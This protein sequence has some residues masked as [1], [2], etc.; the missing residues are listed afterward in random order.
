MLSSR[1]NGSWDN[2]LAP[3]SP[4]T[5]SL[6]IR[7]R[8]PDVETFIA[9][10]GANISPAGIFIHSSNPQPVD[11]RIRFDLALKDGTP[12]LKGEGRVI[13]TR[14]YDA[15]R[16]DHA[17]GMGVRFL[18][19]DPA[20]QQML[21]RIVEAQ[22]LAVD[23]AGRPLTTHAQTLQAFAQAQPG[24]PSADSLTQIA[25]LTQAT[26]ITA[27]APSESSHTLL[28]EAER[29][30]FALMAESGLDEPELL[31]TRQRYTEGLSVEQCER[32]LAELELEF[33]VPAA[34]RRTDPSQWKPE[35]TSRRDIAPTT[36]AAAQQAAQDKADAQAARD[37]A[38][39]QAAQDAADAQ[40]AQNAADA[41]A[42]QNAADAQAAQDAADAADAQAAQD[43]ADAQAAR[44]AADTA[45]AQAAQDA[46]DAQAAR[47]AA[48]AADAQA[49]QDAADAQAA[50]DAAD[51]A[52]AQAAQDAA[53]V[54]TAPSPPSPAPRSGSY[55]L[56][57]SILAAASSVA[58]ATRDEHED[59][60]FDFSE[61]SSSG[62]EP[63]SRPAVPPSGPDVVFRNSDRATVS[64]ISDPHHKLLDG[65][66]HRRS[67]DASVTLENSAIEIDDELLEELAVEEVEDLTSKPGVTVPYATGHEAPPLPHSEFQQT[68]RTG[69][70]APASWPH[71][72]RAAPWDPLTTDSPFSESTVNED[73]DL[74][75]EQA[76]VEDALLDG[77]AAFDDLTDESEQLGQRQQ[78][79]STRDEGDTNVE[80]L[81]PD[82]D[83]E[84]E[85]RDN[86]FAALGSEGRAQEGDG[87]PAL[88]DLV[89]NAVSRAEDGPADEEAQDQPARPGGIFRTL[90]GRK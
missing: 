13:W 57:P 48:D 88:D 69:G 62:H 78:E 38:D 81:L 9:R 21:R 50:R 66:T 86:T 30:L 90:F 47:D 19:L 22:G 39:A 23:D 71:R 12:L 6:R 18:T 16:P 67:T 73:T 33:G 80:V 11:T 42:A 70:A 44:D 53:V 29:A 37:K 4:G 17:H 76:F 14:P 20:S 35:G 56:D 5:I 31:R 24:A 87:V 63:I 52:D 41:Q 85:L 45:D 89:D 65:A 26:S 75:A 84:R 55:S 64:P 40:A 59:Q 60:L 79:A 10:H 51:A 1:T 46:A 36:S 25:A 28:S 74:P 61:V 27:L 77:Y 34:R 2:P 72:E 58:R 82:S 68:I 3:P 15:G 8:Y 7:L 43:A 49:A 83:I 54:Q 32:V